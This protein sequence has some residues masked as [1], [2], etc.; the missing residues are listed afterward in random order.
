MI[1]DSRHTKR[2]PREDI[3]IMSHH[4][5]AGSVKY[6]YPTVPTQRNQQ[7]R[8]G[9]I[10]VGATATT[11]TSTSASSSRSNAT[12]AASST[13]ISSSVSV[14]FHPASQCANESLSIL[15]SY[16]TSLEKSG[17]RKREDC[18]KVLDQMV[19]PL[20]LCAKATKQGGGDESSGSKKRKSGDENEEGG[21]AG[22]DNSVEDITSDRDSTN[23]YHNQLKEE[24]TKQ[25]QQN[26]LLMDRRRNVFRS[27]VALHELYETGLDG[28][29]RMNDL[30][31]VP[32]NVMPNEIP[33]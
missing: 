2:L 9:P 20:F 4:P 25:K 16:A 5:N 19:Q 3:S 21:V 18:V 13:A 31:Y 23:E 7:Q 6:S 1:A 14:K 27:M 11:S 17:K 32:D 24:L 33:H 22:D 8:T 15:G 12:A 30:R 10:I 29:A 28:I 26:Q